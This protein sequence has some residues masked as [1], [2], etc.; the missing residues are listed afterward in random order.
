[1]EESLPAYLSNGRPDFVF[2]HLLIPHPPLRLGADCVFG[3]KPELGGRTVGVSGL[4]SLRLARR[5]A[6]YIDQVE[7]AQST[8]AEVAATMGDNVI[9]LTFGD[10]GPDSGAQLFKDPQDWSQADVDERLRI[11]FAAKASFCS[12]DDLTSLVN[13]GRRLLN[14]LT[15]SQ[16]LQLK[17]R[18]YLATGATG[19]AGESLPIHEVQVSGE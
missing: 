4:D 14:C 15:A 6:A 19:P 7:C 2:L 16:L 11:F 17:D 9:F 5:K 1:L 18:F 8:I 13:V 10:H 12:F 3:W